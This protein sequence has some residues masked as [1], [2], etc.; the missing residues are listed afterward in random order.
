MFV[1]LT[2]TNALQS[3]VKSFYNYIQKLE[4]HGKIRRYLT[5]AHLRGKLENL[6]S[7]IDGE[8]RVV[9][10]ENRSTETRLR[11]FTRIHDDEGQLMWERQ[12][13]SAVELF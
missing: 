8:L 10:T 12:F 5:N 13:G 11:A 3:A 4:E 1:T 9:A 2:A 6:N 7:A